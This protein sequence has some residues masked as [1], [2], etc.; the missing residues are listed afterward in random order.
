MYTLQHPERFLNLEDKDSTRENSAIWVLPLPLERTTCFMGGTSRGPAAIVEV[1]YLL[2]LYDEYIQAEGAIQYDIHTLSSFLPLR[3]S[4]EEIIKAIETYVAGLASGDKLLV[5]LGGEHTITA[6]V[7][8]G[9]S[10]V[11][12]EEFV[13]VQIDARSDLRDNYEG[14]PWSHACAISCSLPYVSQV[15]QFGIRS[16]GQEELDFLNQTDTVQ[17]GSSEAIHRDKNKQYLSEL[18][19]R[20]SGKSVYLTLDVDGFD[21]SVLPDTGTPYPGDWAGTKVWNLFVPS[22]NM[23]TLSLLTVLSLPF[24]TNRLWELLTLSRHWSTRR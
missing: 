4:M 16:V 2:E 8:A 10:Q 11:Y 20:V 18:R 6:R 15:L 22:H 21:P 9:L 5:T 17:I 7:V 14:T 13:L 24:L 19:D 23:G 12:K 3:E 1:S